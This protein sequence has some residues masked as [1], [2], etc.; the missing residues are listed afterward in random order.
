MANE[1]RDIEC[2]QPRSRLLAGMSNGE[3]AAARWPEKCCVTE[4]LVLN[5]AQKVTPAVS[6]DTGD[7]ITLVR[8]VVGAVDGEHGRD[9]WNR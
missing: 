6:L 1:G 9:H 2:F 5:I 4:L 3:L 7:D 8:P